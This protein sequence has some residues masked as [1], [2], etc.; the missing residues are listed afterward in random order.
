MELHTSRVQL[1][2]FC[3]ERGTVIG[4][5]GGQWGDEGK[6]KVVDELQTFTEVNVR[7]EGGGNAG[8]TVYKNGKKIVLNHLPSGILNLKSLN[9][10]GKGMVINLKTVV[11]EIQKLETAGIPVRGQKRIVLMGGAQAI[12]PSLQGKMD[13]YFSGNIG[14]TGRGIG[15][16]YAL[17]ALR[18]SVN[19]NDMYYHPDDA[20]AN[21]ETVVKSFGEQLGITM[22]EVRQ[23]FQSHRE[24]LL[25][26]IKEGT[27]VLDP[28]NE[29]ALNAYESGKRIVL[30]GAQGRMLGLEQGTYPYVTSSDT[31]F[32]GLLSGSGLP[33]IHT[34][35]TVQKPYETRV[36]NGP[37]MSLL[38]NEEEETNIR[39]IIGEKGATTSRDRNV[40]WYDKVTSRTIMR[41][42]EPDLLVITKV[43]VLPV[44]A[45]EIK[46]RLMK[47]IEGYDVT[48][49]I[50]PRYGISQGDVIR[51]IIPPINTLEGRGNRRYKG[52]TPVS[53]KITCP[54][55][56]SRGVTSFEQ[57]SEKYKR[58]VEEIL[59]DNGY[60]GDLAMLGTGP[61]AGEHCMTDITR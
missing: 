18:K 10:L 13:G 58:Y 8:H 2:K 57:L 54:D 50:D 22:D 23:E 34:K 35:I 56:D 28:L 20:L 16:A 19:F 43:D 32:N 60:H 59:R 52:L 33:K 38:D 14:T 53:V 47:I 48:E 42:G 30:E 26:L 17:R 1:E 36:G 25:E 41:G 15:P 11:E 39:N 40:G 45:R 37:M 12:F 29:S 5:E 24:L 9:I 55:E 4:I 21:L 31:T 51:N 3:H 7:P 6:G 49:D 27:I 46:D 61:H 44:F